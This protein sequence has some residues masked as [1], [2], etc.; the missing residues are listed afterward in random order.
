MTDTT[1][2]TLSLRLKTETA[3]EHDRME[4]LMEQAKVFE[5]KENYAQFTLSQYYFQRDIEY[6]YQST[7]VG[8]V[9]PD[10]DIRGR[11]EAARQ[12]L[13][14]LGIQPQGMDISTLHVRYPQALGWIYVSEGSTLGA[15]FLFK[16]AQAKLGF[17]ADFAAR[18][19]AAYPEGRMRVW[20]RFKQALDDAQFS[21]SEQ[22]QV[23]DGAM[24]AFA[25]FGDLLSHLDT[26]K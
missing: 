3:I 8:A 1:Q 14:D 11:S 26:L 22:Q 16:E 12:D 19:L 2:N 17:S 24:Q 6:L 20:K 18:N 21:P 15:A 9:I 10:L 5:S 13:T 25:H 23:V 7:A 4:M